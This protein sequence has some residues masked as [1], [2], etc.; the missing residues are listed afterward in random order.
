MLPQFEHLRKQYQKLFE[1]E[2]FPC[3][4]Y[5]SGDRIIKQ[6][7]ILIT[8]VFT[9]WPILRQK[10][11]NDTKFLPDMI[12]AHPVGGFSIQTYYNPKYQE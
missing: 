9:V 2:N 3:S 7:C 4:E 8:R 1:K 5:I 11:Y 6:M 12:A 10:F